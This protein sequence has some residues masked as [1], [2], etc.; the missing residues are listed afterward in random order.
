MAKPNGRSSAQQRRKFDEA[1]FFKYLKDNADTSLLDFLRLMDKRACVEMSTY[2]IRYLR[3]SEEEPVLAARRK[4]GREI[5]K[6]LSLAIRE[7]Q[8]ASAS[9]KE[10]AAIELPG[11]GPLGTSG[12]RIWPAGEPS[13][14]DVLKAEEEKLLALLEDQKKLYNEKR[15]G[16]SGNHMWLVMLQ[17]FV[18]AW[19]ERELGEARELRSEDIATMIEAAKATLGW[20]EDKSETDAELIR[21]AIST[22][23][24]NQSNAGFVSHQIIPYVQNR[25]SVVAEGPYLLGIEI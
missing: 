12:S 9:Y 14:L 11:T 25:C 15:F 23:R 1:K 16:V 6:A 7:L 19:T 8:K 18:S 17:E 2:V 20:R 10:L 4:R 3:R 21:K 5:G 13:F 22:F 24:K